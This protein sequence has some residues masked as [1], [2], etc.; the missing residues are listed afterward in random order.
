[1][2]LHQVLEQ[3]WVRFSQD[4]R[5]VIITISPQNFTVNVGYTL[6]GASITISPQNFTVNVGYTPPGA[7]NSCGT[8]A[9]STTS[10]MDIDSLMQGVDLEEFSLLELLYVLV[11]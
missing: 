11:A 2:L 9:V 3:C 8:P 10:H 6:P 4:F 1:M 7:S 5:T